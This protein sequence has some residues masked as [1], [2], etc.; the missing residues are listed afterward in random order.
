MVK[1]TSPSYT[2]DQVKEAI[3]KLLYEKW[4]NPTAMDSAKPKINEIKRALKKIGIE[5]AQVIRNLQY[6]I[7]TGWVKEIVKT[8]TFRTGSRLVNAESTS[9]MIGSQGIEY[10]E[11]R[12]IFEKKEGTAGIRIE[13]VSGVVTIG[14]HNIIRQEFVPLFKLLDDFDNRIRMTDQLTDDQK[15]D[16]SS[17]VKTIQTQLSK[18]NPDRD[19]IGKAWG[20]LKGIATFGSLATVAEKVKTGIEQAI[21]SLPPPS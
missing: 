15:L 8:S 17:D 6:L 2:D 11:G 16:Y 5:R 9:Y 20:A 14:D 21:G 13:N 10:F 1:R 18:P 4:K 3:L 7:D 19:I 12:S